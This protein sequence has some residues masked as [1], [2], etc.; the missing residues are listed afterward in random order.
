M[1]D[2]HLGIPG[3]TGILWIALLISGKLVVNRKATGL[4][5]GFAAALWGIPMGM[6]HSP[7]YNV[8]LYSLTGG[9][10]D[11]LTTIPGMRIDH[12][13]GAAIC[14]ALAHLTKLGFITAYAMSFGLYRN[15]LEVGLV[16]SAGYHILFGALGGVLVVAIVAAMRLPRIRLPK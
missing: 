13:F 11:L 15:F 12:L 3:H 10:I 5:M 2:F 7:V 8:A 6:G 1:L 9:A 4:G 16:I 14:G